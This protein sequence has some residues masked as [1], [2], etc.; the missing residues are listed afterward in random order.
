MPY[1]GSGQTPYWIAIANN[2]S[3]SNAGMQSEQIPVVVGQTYNATVSFEYNT[4]YASGGTIGL[5]IYNAAGGVLASAAGGTQT[6]MTGG[7]TYSLGSGNVTAP[8][9]A[10]YAVC[11]IAQ[12]GLPAIANPLNVYSAQVNDLSNTACNINF[13]FVYSYFPW[14]STNNAALTWNYNPKLVGDYDSLVLD[15]Q[16]ELLGG[17]GGGNG[18]TFNG[19]QCTLPELLDS[20]GVGP[21]F[22]ILAPP[23]LN[24]AAI[25]YQASL[26]LN[27]PQPT[28]D[29]IASMLLDGER[30]FGTRSSNRQMTIPIMIFGS[31]AGGIAQ[32]LTAREYLMSVIDQQT[33]TM[34]WTAADTGLP[35]LF[36]CFRALPTQVL[37]GF[38]H[39][40]GLG[41]TSSAKPNMPMA[42]VTIQV[43]A[44][45][46]GRSDL[47]GIQSIQFSNGLVSGPASPAAVAIDNFAT[48][49]STNWVQDTQTYA[50]LGG[51]SAKYREPTPK[52]IPHPL[53]VYNSSMAAPVSISGLPVLSFW[54]GQAYDKQWP[55][56]P[57]FVSNVTF[58]VTLT[59]NNGKHLSFHT[60]K[61]K[62]RWSNDIRQPYWSQVNLAIPQNATGFNYSQLSSYKIVMS[63]WHGSGQ[64]G[65]VR[66]YAFLNS[67]TAQPQTTSNPTSPRGTVYNMF[68][69]PGSARSPI[70]LEAQ[71]PAAAPL[72]REFTS[73]GSG[74]W[75][76]PAGVYS[77]SAEAWA[78][79][80]AGGT[81][82]C[83]ETYLQQFN[84]LL[85]APL[86]T[87]ANDLSGNGYN[88]TPSNVTFNNSLTQV[89][90]QFSAYLNGSTSSIVFPVNVYDVQ[91]LT[92]GM[93]VNF[94]N[95]TPTSS[96]MLV[97]TSGNTG[98]TG[99]GWALYVN[100]STQRFELQIG[101]ASSNVT[102]QGTAS[103]YGNVWQHIAFTYSNGA[104]V[105]YQNGVAVGSN[106]LTGGIGP[107]PSNITVGL[108]GSVHLNAYVQGLAVV[109]NALTAAQVA[110]LAN[111]AVPTGGGGGGAEWAAEPVLAV[112]PGTKIPWTVGAGGIAAQVF[113][114]VLQFLKADV[115]SHWTCPAGVTSVLVEAFGAGAA[116]AAGGG[117]GGGGG[118]A[119]QVV[120][121]TPGT[122]YYMRVGKGGTANTGTSAAERAARQGGYSWFATSSAP[123]LTAAT[124][125]ANGGTSGLTGATAGGK[126]G[127]T[128]GAIGTIKWTGGNGGNS[129][130][131][132]GGGGGGSAGA[133]GVGSKGGDAY[134]AP[135]GHYGAG[136]LGGAGDGQGGAGG[137]GANAP[138]FPSKGIMPGGGGGGGYTGVQLARGINVPATGIPVTST[139]VNFLGADGA[140]GMVQ[141][142]YSIGSGTQVNGGNSTFGSAGT[143]GTTV[144]A[145]GGTSQ[146]AN[147]AYASAGGALMGSAAG[148]SG[149]SNTLHNN[150]GTGGIFQNASGTGFGTGAGAWNAPIFG[151]R[152]GNAYALN[153]CAAGTFTSYT[154]T[155]ATSAS[156]CTQGVSIVLISTPNPVSDLVVTDSAG[157]TYDFAD[158]AQAG[159]G[160]NGAQ[161]SA[162]IANIAAPISTGTT[163]TILGATPQVYAYLWYTSPYLSSGL[164]T[165]NLASNHGTGTAVS[166]TFNAGD[167]QS[168]QYQLVAIVNDAAATVNAPTYSN[169]MWFAAN[170]TNSVTGTG[171]AMNAYISINQGGGV[172]GVT[173]DNFAA[174]LSGTA[175]WAALCIPLVAAAQG[176]ALIKG[177]LNTFS[178]A[179]GASSTFTLGANISANGVIAVVGQSASGAPT[180]VVDASGNQYFAQTSHVLPSSNVTQWCFT[181]V[182]TAGLAQGATGTIHW[183]AASASNIGQ[184]NVY[185]IPNAGLTDNAG[186]M[187]TTG[188]TSAVSAGFQPDQANDLVLAVISNFASPSGH[189]STHQ[190]N[191]WNFSEY[192]PIGTAPDQIQT[193]VFL[194]QIPGTAYTSI[195]GSYAANVNWS[196]QMIGLTTVSFAGGGGAAGGVSGAGWHATSQYGAPGFGGG[197]HGGN[198]GII[199]GYAGN[200][201]TVP[202]GGGGGGG[203][204]VHGPN[205]SAAGGNGG[206]GLIRVT[207]QPPLTPLNALILHRPGLNS[208]ANFNPLVPIPVTDLPA[209]VEYTV[210]VPSLVGYL[211]AEFNSTYTIILSAYAWNSATQGSPRNITV[212]VNQYEFPGGPRYTVQASRTVTPATDVINGLVNMG[213]VTL[214]IKDYAR[215]ND[216]SYFT[217]SIMDSDQGDSFQDLLFL[218]T[219]GQTAI[220]NIA[221]GTPGYGTYVNYFIDEP[222][223]DRDL[224]FVGATTDGRQHSVSVFE[225]AMLAGGPFF[226]DPGDNLLLAYSPNGAPNIGLTY[227]P[228]WYLDR[229]Q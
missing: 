95:V 186:V 22:R 10:A 134:T 4:T 136:G 50:P 30:P 14:S 196:A 89:N 116:G 91:Q 145:H 174:T 26:D 176:C 85:Y 187:Y 129:P 76:V 52:Q 188:N 197:A 31:Q 100:T 109:E 155:S 220:I 122:T 6:N 88:G 132:G 223:A 28:Q 56:D 219:T 105:L 113:P 55:S 229:I 79:G 210:P 104:V 184:Y 150:G 8:A 173:G 61:N 39:S 225:Y 2:G 208:P 142:T 73:A 154:G 69:L 59:D 138:G 163:I 38:N 18:F 200:G 33:W 106:A 190:N 221:P 13:A 23:S 161:I 84:Q 99:P 67:V 228:R 227:A 121:V 226:L 5:V 169:S 11:T 133:L 192:M 135:L 151:A 206:A 46:Y 77:V 182:I 9:N 127:L 65:Y 181:S 62:C 167:Q 21:V 96:P 86:S 83:D 19:V 207:W 218:D 60:T 194:T 216:Q 34:K 44:L 93:W 183:G 81:V 117:G 36:D 63:N 180:S 87:N 71:L 75:Q 57:K 72:T 178:S 78:G 64:Y 147:T 137:T 139:T 82:A 217:V 110:L 51:N 162:F 48:V 25:G 179:P 130:G 140:D 118:Y 209:N 40:I 37:Y 168:I 215:H 131:L 1:S 172:S 198:G 54:F 204:L 191:P 12:A 120:T 171:V 35:M 103:P 17:M 146:S 3:T 160:A 66:M 128:S 114:T 164:A 193:D 149:S 111:S 205:T 165:L 20:N 101:N 211:N 195:T 42:M 43:Q 148:G 15:G 29:V 94:N 212:S 16:I 49:S 158:S 159:S 203:L 47:D 199:G 157:N 202:G 189:L 41:Q 175:N 115:V 177:S 58:Q 53:A 97:G 108:T 125:I 185:W 24:S 124:V 152:E 68:G 74:T 222:S 107:G 123:K 201:G 7:V 102:V 80:G 153:P 213:E 143:T 98:A 170:A 166:A 126:G 119:S 45:P 92:V 141:L 214:P 90:G 27:A 112:T 224:G 144:T 32:V 156:S 70:N